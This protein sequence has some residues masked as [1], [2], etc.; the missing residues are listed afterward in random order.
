MRERFIAAIVL[1][2]GVLA[3]GSLLAAS[4]QVDDASTSGS[5]TPAS[6]D[7]AIGDRVPFLGQD[8]VERAALTVESVTDPVED[9]SLSVTPAPGTRLIAIELTVTNTGTEP[10]TINPFD[11]LLQDDRGFLGTQAAL[12]F[13]PDAA[14][15]GPGS[16]SVAPGESLTGQVVFQIATD[17]RP[18][19]LFYAPEPGRLVTLADLRL[20]PGGEE[21]ATPQAP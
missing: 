7:P 1:L 9:G 3:G 2:M 16:A 13:A 4:A 8:G 14:T 11:F 17:A 6:G 5:A 10:L 15:S 19:H 20:V 18:A 12:P 21:I